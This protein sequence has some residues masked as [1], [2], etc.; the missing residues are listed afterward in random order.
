LIEQLP[1]IPRALTGLAEWA[2]CLVGVWP[3]RRFRPWGFGLLM[4]VAGVFQVT[5]QMLL[6]CAPLGLWIPGMATA[7]LAMFAI[8]RLGAG[9]SRVSNSVYL[10]VKAFMLAELVAAVH[11]QMHCFL[12]PAT[13]D[14]PMAFMVTFG[15]IVYGSLFGA[16]WLIEVRQAASGQPFQVTGRDLPV[17]IALAIGTFCLSNLSFLSTNT[18]FSGRLGAEVFYIRT[19][20]DLA[21]LVALYAWQG[22]RQQQRA[23]A[24][25]AAIEGLLR[26]QHEQYLLSKRAMDAVNRTYHDLK[27]QVAVIRREAD[28]ALRDRHITELESSIIGYQAV[29]RTGNEV[30]DVIVASKG[31]VFQERGIEFTCVADG[32][33]VSFVS[34]VDLCT[35]LGN[36][37]DNA[38]EAAAR[39]PDPSQRLIKLSL[40]TQNSFVVMTVENSFD[41]RIVMRDGEIVTSHSDADHHGFGLKSIAYVVDRYGGSLTARPDG[42]WFVLR[43]LLPIP[44]SSGRREAK[45]DKP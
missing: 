4:S 35:I 2:A 30:V 10:T 24:E 40:F 20:V 22:Q 21:G 41:G 25:V 1:D 34:V 17:P 12:F 36:A 45:T 15:A 27:H 39:L 43:V 37:L 18:P 31:T 28:S 23:K 32:A 29:T 8:I 9:R 33:A 38:I 26:A 44:P 11:W 14:V 3:W 19:L 13:K 5:L 16:A 6:G 42:D 7:V